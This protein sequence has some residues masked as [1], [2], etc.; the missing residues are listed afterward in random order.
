VVKE[1]DFE[2]GCW[3]IREPKL[4]VCKKYVPNPDEKICVIMPGAVFDEEG[5]RIGYGGG[6]YDKYLQRLFQKREDI[7]VQVVLEIYKIALAFECQIVEANL[8]Q[9]E[10]HDVKIDC[11]ISENRIIFK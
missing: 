8:I 11:I 7:D 4:E 3:G 9:R 1:T 5:N 10:E 6:Y 2:S